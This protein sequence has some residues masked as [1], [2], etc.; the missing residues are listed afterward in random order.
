MAAALPLPKA[1]ELAHKVSIGFLEVN[2]Y[3]R[4]QMSHGPSQNQAELLR[5]PL[6]TWLTQVA[7]RSPSFPQKQALRA[8]YSSSVVVPTVFK[9]C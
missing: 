1:T 8:H 4:S 9:I 5:F 2:E 6:E 7:S 3:N